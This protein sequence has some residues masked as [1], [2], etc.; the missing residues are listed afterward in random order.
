MVGHLQL[1]AVV[2][3]AEHV[4]KQQQLMEILVNSTLTLRKIRIG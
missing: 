4:P 1:V 3:V 2:K